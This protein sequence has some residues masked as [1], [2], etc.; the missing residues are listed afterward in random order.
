LCEQEQEAERLLKVKLEHRISNKAFG[1]MRGAIHS[2][3]ISSQYA[4]NKVMKRKKAKLQQHGIEPVVFEVKTEDREKPLK[5]VRVPLAAMLNMEVEK[6]VKQ[7]KIKEGDK[8]RVK[9]NGDGRDLG[10]R[11]KNSSVLVTFCLL[12][13]SDP[14]VDRNIHTLLLLQGSEEEE[15]LRKGLKSTS[16]ENSLHPLCFVQDCNH[17][18]MR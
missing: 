1:S 16:A 18:Q 5:A 9:I 14:H 2:T 11:G 4:L 10:K 13:N 15:A 12:N 8:L 3:N 6:G 7:N 17:L